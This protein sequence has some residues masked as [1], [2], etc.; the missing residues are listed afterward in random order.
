MGEQS[1]LQTRI[2]MTENVSLCARMEKMTAF[3]ELENGRFC[4]GL[5]TEQI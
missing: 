2:G 5:L 4:I 1:G 3:T